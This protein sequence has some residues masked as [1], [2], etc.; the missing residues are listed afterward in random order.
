[1]VTQRAMPRNEGLAIVTVS[2][3]PAEEVPFGEIRDV[4]L[5][6]LVEH[7]GLQVRDVQKCPFGRGQ[8]YVRLARIS[9]RDGLV[10][11]SPHH[12]RGF[13]LRFVNHSRGDNARRVNFNRECWLML[14]GYPPDYRSNEEIGDTIKSFGRLL[15]WQRDNIVARVIIKTRVTD[16]SDVPHYIIIFEGDGYEGVSLNHAA[17]YAGWNATR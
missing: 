7:Y 12:H 10:A 3:L 15:F 8:A 2:P 6:L 14:I 17:E 11:S 1:M 9:N 13:T 5:G 4:T 16:L